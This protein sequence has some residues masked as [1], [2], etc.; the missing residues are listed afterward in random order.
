MKK[1]NETPINQILWPL[2][3]QHTHTQT[4]A[5]THTPLLPSRKLTLA[6]LSLQDTS[7]ALR[8]V[9]QD[10]ST[11]N[12]SHL[13]LPPRLSCNCGHSSSWLGVTV[14]QEPCWDLQGHCYILNPKTSPWGRCSH[15]LHFTD[16][17]TEA[18]P[19]G[20]WTLPRCQNISGLSWAPAWVMHFFTWRLHLWLSTYPV[21]NTVSGV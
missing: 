1:K 20:P 12:P 15:F 3:P 19:G 4:H 9:P 17:Q 11:G 2:Y 18:V 7:D 16:E 13:L 10:V 8:Q 5:D 21:C 14:G 6:L